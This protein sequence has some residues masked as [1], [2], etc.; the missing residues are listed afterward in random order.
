MKVWKEAGG[1]RNGA[2][3][4]RVSEE[5]SRIF[6]KESPPSSI[7]EQLKF[8]RPAIAQKFGLRGVRKHGTAQS[9]AEFLK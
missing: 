8:F 5:V 4:C 9:G 1:Q 6:K 7:K 2:N 3:P